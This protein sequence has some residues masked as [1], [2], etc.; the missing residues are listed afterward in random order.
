[1]ALKT[2]EEAKSNFEAAIPF[3]SERYSRGVKRSDW[4]TPAGSDVAEAN[5]AKAITDAV[6]KKRRQAGVKKVSNTE[7]QNKAIGK[8]APVIGDRIRAALGDWITTWGPMYDRVAS[9]VAALPPRTV[10][11]R[12]NVNARLIPTVEEWKRAAGKL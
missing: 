3:I 4:A 10:D 2:K 8:G 11:F 12:A 6:A 1:M 7:W 5:Y 9:K